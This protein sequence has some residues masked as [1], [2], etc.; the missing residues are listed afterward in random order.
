[1]TAIAIAV[2][3]LGLIVWATLPSPLPLHDPQWT[4]KLY[5]VAWRRYY[6]TVWMHLSR[7]EV[8]R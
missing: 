5:R 3:V 6:V 7:E 2:L 8:E 4:R 1:M